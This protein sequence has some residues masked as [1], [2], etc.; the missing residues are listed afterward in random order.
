MSSIVE[1]RDHPAGIIPEKYLNYPVHALSG[2][3]KKKLAVAIANIGDPDLLLLDEC[4][5]GVDPLAADKIISYLQKKLVVPHSNQS[6]LFASHRIDECSTLCDRVVI[7]HRGQVFFDGGMQ[8][9]ELIA[10]KFFQ[11]DVIL[12]NSSSSPLPGLFLDYDFEEGGLG[13]KDIIEKC[14]QE[15]SG[16]VRGID[17]VVEYSPSYLRI[18]LER[19]HYKI[20]TVL[21][22][23]AHL[24]SG[25]FPFEVDRLAIREMN[26]EEALSS[27][28]DD[29]LKKSAT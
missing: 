3:N 9:F 6:L 25:S 24:R 15:A 26:M 8:A 17:R 28:F 10:T 13:F 5:T 19:Q 23:L 16:N 18:T 14:F 27:I 1:R 11:V 12:S 20:S 22:V 2:G 7:L 21:R 29:K 4:S